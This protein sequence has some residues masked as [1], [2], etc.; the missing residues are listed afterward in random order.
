MNYGLA[1]AENRPRSQ[2]ALASG[3]RISRKSVRA[4]YARNTWRG[5]RAVDERLLAA[6]KRKEP[7]ERIIKL[8]VALKSTVDP[9]F[10]ISC[11]YRRVYVFIIAEIRR[12]NL[13]KSETRELP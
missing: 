8:P 3:A 11:T 13:D 2:C 1:T 12:E 5:E 4:Q 6:E 9:R 10:S 7:D